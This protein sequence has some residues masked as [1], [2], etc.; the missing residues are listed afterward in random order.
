M[1]K[2]IYFFIFLIL[3]IIIAK[4][5][6]S[7]LKEDCND[8]SVLV[9]LVFFVASL[10]M[11]FVIL[12][13]SPSKGHTYRVLSVS[14]CSEERYC[15]LLKENQENPDRIREILYKTEKTNENKMIEAGDN[16][17]YTNGKEL[18]IMEKEITVPEEVS[19]P[20]EKESNDSL[21]EVS[22]PLS[23]ENIIPCICE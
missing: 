4:I 16:V 17:F 3:L 20:I 12:L 18:K 21:E 9:V 8:L 5:A 7:F 6:S 19:V 14:E 22:I 13:E 2:M 10:G 1:V 11:T 23:Q 15:F